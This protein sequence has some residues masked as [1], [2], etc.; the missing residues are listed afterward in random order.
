MSEETLK[1]GA[2]AAAGA[3]VDEQALRDIEGPDDGQHEV[4]ETSLITQPSF[5]PSKPGTQL[6]VGRISLPILQIA[7]GVG[8]LNTQYGHTPGDVVLDNE[9]VLYV[10]PRIANKNKGTAPLRFIIVN[11]TPYFKEYKAQEGQN[12]RAF[13]TAAE[14]RA[15]GLTTERDEVTGALPSAPPAMSWSMLIEKP[16][17]MMSSHFCIVDGVDGKEYA[18]ARMFVERSAYLAVSSDFGKANNFVCRARGINS[19]VWEMT[20]KT[21]RAKT[22]NNE[23]WVPAIRIVEHLTEEKLARLDKLLQPAG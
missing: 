15:A 2:K 1:G 18:P 17:G 12:P 10:P 20:T 19:V 4:G 16:E 13:R 21:R 23:T 7:H 5:A 3:D 8:K 11:W 9:T 14:A 6:F 22:T